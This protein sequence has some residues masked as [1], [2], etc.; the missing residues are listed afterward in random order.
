MKRVFLTS[1]LIFSLFVLGTKISH[2]QTPANWW[3]PTFKEFTN[4]VGVD[5]A[6]GGSPANEIF[7]ERYTLA[8]INWI[9]N[10]LAHVLTGR[11]TQ[12]A[13]PMSPDALAECLKTVDSGGGGA[14]LALSAA[15]DSFMSNKPA[16]GVNYVAQKLDRLEIVESAN[17][18]EGYGFSSSLAPI[19]KLWLAARNAA[20]ALTTLA[21]VILALM[22]TLQRRVSPQVAITAQSAI[23]R[24]AVALVFITFS[25]AIAGLIVD[26]T[27]VAQGV[28][29]ALV[30]AGGLSTKSAVDL[31][32]A[33]NQG[34]Q[35]LFSFGVSYILQSLA[36]GGVLSQLLGA[37]IVGNLVIGLDS[38]ISLFIFFLLFIA[39]IRIFWLLLRTYA[40]A[41]FLVIAAPFVGVQHI[42]S[43]GGNPIQGWIKNFASQMGVFFMVGVGILGVHILFFSMGNGQDFI[44]SGIIGGL[45]QVN[46]FGIIP[47]TVNAGA[48]RLPSGFS[49]QSISSIGYFV[50]LVGALSL[51]KIAKAFG[52]QIATGK[53][54]YGAEAT[55]TI[56]GGGIP[57]LGAIGAHAYQQGTKNIPAGALAYANA[58][59]QVRRGRNT[60]PPP[61]DQQ[62]TRTSSPRRSL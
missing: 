15:S 24:V 49:F 60:P 25:Y 59:W 9:I 48:G 55:G 47:Q 13:K 41:V 51:T 35:S 28:V 12:C 30:S 3:E 32:N 18:Q 57:V 58:L 43:P 8:Q 56:L 29:G 61:A 4:K 46:P 34:V 50:S 5:P 33:M 2:A 38:L 17:A 14:I 31:F 22:V 40:V 37:G 23:P 39:M 62:N 44:W 27:F 45:L 26:L 11:I 54:A 7:G 20:Y 10:S 6:V 42:L 16:S 1:F 52:D 21:M 53:G 36:A 19:Q